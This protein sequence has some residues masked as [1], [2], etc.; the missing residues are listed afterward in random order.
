ME[1]SHFVAG[2]ERSRWEVEVVVV[3][4]QLELHHLCLLREKSPLV[5]LGP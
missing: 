2:V 3:G 1:V 5:T 4:N